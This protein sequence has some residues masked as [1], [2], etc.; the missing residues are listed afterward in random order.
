MYACVLEKTRPMLIYPS[1]GLKTRDA[2][3]CICTCCYGCKIWAVLTSTV[4]ALRFQWWHSVSIFSMKCLSFLLVPFTV[5]TIRS[6]L[7][8]QIC[9]ISIL[10]YFI[11]SIYL[12]FELKSAIQVLQL[13]IEKLQWITMLLDSKVQMQNTQKR[14]GLLLI[15]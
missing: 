7:Q 3:L 14:E 11:Y 5:T 1:I 12:Q 15:Q 10:F 6:T 9:C 13:T 2:I 4:Y 8:F